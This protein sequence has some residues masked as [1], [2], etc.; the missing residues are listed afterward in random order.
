MN[1]DLDVIFPETA[2]ANKF[3]SFQFL[4]TN[5]MQILKLM[6]IFPGK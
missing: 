2:T 6:I 1:S 5:S 3:P 4:L